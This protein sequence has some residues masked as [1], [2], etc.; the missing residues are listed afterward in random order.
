[1]F[2][3]VACIIF[4]AYKGIERFNATMQAALLKSFTASVTGVLARAYRTPQHSAR[5]TPRATQRKL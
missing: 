3:V 1:V 5:R 2:E 4:Y